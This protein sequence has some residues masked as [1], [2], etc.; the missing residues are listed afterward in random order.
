M[1]YP[2]TS[3]ETLWGNARS[4]LCGC[5]A[6]PLPTNVAVVGEFAALLA[7]KALTDAMPLV[8]GLNVTPN[9]TLCPAEM[10]TG[11]LSPLMANSEPPEFALVIVTLARS[12]VRIP[13]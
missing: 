6:T 4:T 2:V 7:N 12:A 11:N 5:G 8:R 13:V 9:L 10:V 3:D 1:L